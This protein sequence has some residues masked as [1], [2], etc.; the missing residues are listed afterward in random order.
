MLERGVLQWE[1]VITMLMREIFEISGKIFILMILF[2]D[3]ISFVFLFRLFV[4]FLSISIAYGMNVPKAKTSAS[5]SKKIRAC[6][7]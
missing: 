6:G 7:C 4:E 1:F 3:S 2:V 5:I